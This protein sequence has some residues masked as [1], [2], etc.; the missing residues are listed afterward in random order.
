MPAALVLADAARFGGAEPSRQRIASGRIAAI[1]SLW[2]RT[3]PAVAA[4]VVFA[5]GP[6]PSSLPALLDLRGNPCLYLGFDPADSL[7]T[8]RHR[9]GKGR[10]IVARPLGVMPQAGR[11]GR[12]GKPGAGFNL[13]A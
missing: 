9:L 12:S 8:D 6:P 5:H 2:G 7:C 10:V 11:D 1:G 3:V 4:L 13:L